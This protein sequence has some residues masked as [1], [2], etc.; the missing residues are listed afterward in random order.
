MVWV[1]ASLLLTAY[2]CGMLIEGYYPYFYGRWGDRAG[3]AV[4]WALQ[5][6]CLWLLI[7]HSG[8]RVCSAAKLLGGACVFVAVV[9]SSLIAL[10]YFAK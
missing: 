4:T 8:A 9:S 6:G 3:C 5:A 7:D 1:A 10:L 2:H